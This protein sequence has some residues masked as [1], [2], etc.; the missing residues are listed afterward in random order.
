[1]KKLSVAGFAVALLGGAVVMLGQEEAQLPKPGKEHA[2]LEQL[3]GE[4]TAEVEALVEPGKPPVKSEGTES[5]RRIGGF[6]IVAENK[7][8]IMGQSFTG[9]LTLGYDTRKKQYVGTWIDS[10]TDYLWRYE[11][12]VDA[13]GKV[14]TLQTEGPSQA[15]P[16]KL[17]RFKDVIELKAKDHKVLTSSMQGD[18]G[19]WT[20]IMTINYRRKK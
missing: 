17:A 19:K 4:W 9:L 3:A 16:G 10:M 15:G 6:W 5:V 12:T 20:T 11:G 2:W 14:L 7:G 8:D 13:S 1:M 18:D